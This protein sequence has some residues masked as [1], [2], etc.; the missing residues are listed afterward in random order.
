MSNQ[1]DG[2][3]RLRLQ[4]AEI[5]AAVLSDSTPGQASAREQLWQCLQAHPDRPEIALVE[6]LVALREE[7]G[8][9]GPPHLFLVPGEAAGAETP[10][11]PSRTGSGGILGLHS[12]A[13]RPILHQRPTLRV[14]YGRP[15]RG[16]L[17]GMAEDGI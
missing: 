2:D 10:T 14:H 11:P 12:G 13:R 17:G 3:A 4:A 15:D 5:I 16:G 6:H 1:E 8:R 7:A 9:R